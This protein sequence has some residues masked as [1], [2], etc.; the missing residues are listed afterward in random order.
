MPLRDE[1]PPLDRLMDKLMLWLAQQPE[2]AL[3]LGLNDRQTRRRLGEEVA[4]RVTTIPTV[5]G[6]TMNRAARRRVTGVD[7]RGG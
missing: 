1:V 5:G 3:L 7:K 4:R 6:S 2:Y